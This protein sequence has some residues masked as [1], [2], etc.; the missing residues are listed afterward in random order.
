M[1]CWQHPVGSIWQGDSRIRI[2]RIPQAPTNR[3]GVGEVPVR[4]VTNPKA[5]VVKVSVTDCEALV[6]FRV[7]HS[8]SAGTHRLTLPLSFTGPIAHSAWT[9]ET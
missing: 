7:P 1:P 5:S 9:L 4:E 6:S 2:G 3:K 8:P